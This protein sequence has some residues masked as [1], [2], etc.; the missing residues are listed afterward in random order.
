MCLDMF[1][2]SWRKTEA[3]KQEKHAKADRSKNLNG[4][5]VKG[6]TD[7]VEVYF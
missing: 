6:K 7:G 1:F 4:L 3:I 5:L 2:F